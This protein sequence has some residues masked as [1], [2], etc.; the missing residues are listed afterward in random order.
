MGAKE[1]R[2]KE[3]DRIEAITTNLRNMGATIETFED[4]FAIQGKTNLKPTHI[5]TFHDPSYR[6][7]FQDCRTTYQ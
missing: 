7:E 1:L 6:N 3:S 4:G 2:L 5:Q